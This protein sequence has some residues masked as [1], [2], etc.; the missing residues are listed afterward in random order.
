MGAGQEWVV[1]PP[2][3]FR[4]ISGKIHRSLQKPC[5]AYV[6]ASMHALGTHARISV[7]GFMIGFYAGF[8]MVRIDVYFLVDVG[9]MFGKLEVL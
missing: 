7:A 6:C 2:L 1:L 4:I 5:F 3:S 8:I 9:Q